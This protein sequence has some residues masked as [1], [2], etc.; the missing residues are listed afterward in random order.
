VW[1]SRRRVFLD[2]GFRKQ[3]VA[4][5]LRFRDNVPKLFPFLDGH[6]RLNGF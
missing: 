6:K 2:H 1:A 5:P 4:R 3:V